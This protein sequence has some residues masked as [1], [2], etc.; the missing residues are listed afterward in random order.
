MYILLLCSITGGE[1]AKF[2]PSLLALFSN[3]VSIV[4]QQH[5]FNNQKFR[6]SKKDDFQL[7]VQMVEPK[8]YQKP[9]MLY[10]NIPYLN[11]LFLIPLQDD[12]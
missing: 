3:D 1:R 7:T 10:H 5:L 8:N 2:M 11:C 9:Y 12:S 4:Y 6:V